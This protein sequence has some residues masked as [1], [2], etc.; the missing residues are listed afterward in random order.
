MSILD[1]LG[2]KDEKQYNKAQSEAI[3]MFN[4]QKSSIMALE[5]SDGLKTI[6]NYWEQV[7]NINENMFEKAKMEDKDKYFALYKQSKMFIEFINNL[8]EK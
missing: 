1:L 5:G 6:V 3:E 8:L 2:D 4:K 7:K